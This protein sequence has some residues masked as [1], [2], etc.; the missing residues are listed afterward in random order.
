MSRDNRDRL[1]LAIG[2]LLIKGALLLALGPIHTPD[3]GGYAAYAQDILAGRLGD[4]GLYATTG[5]TTLFRVIGFPAVIAAFM[6]MGGPYWDWMLVIVQMLLSVAASLG[7]HVM[8]RRFGLNRGLAACAV[9]AAAVSLPLALDQAV[10]TDSPFSTLILACVLLLTLPLLAGRPV[11]VA[12]TLAAGLLF[13]AAF[14]LREATLFLSLGI[15]PLVALAGLGGT[16]PS[17]RGARHM[18]VVGIVFMTPLLLVQQG[19]REWNRARIGMPVITTGAQTTMFQALADAAVIDPVVLKGDD[20]VHRTARDMLQGDDFSRVLAMLDVLF[21]QHRMTAVDQMQAGFAAYF[22]AWRD[23]PGIMARMVL[24]HLRSNQAQLALRPVESVRELILWARHDDGGFARWRSVREGRW[25]MAPVVAMDGL[26]KAVSI[27]VF[28]AFVLLTPWR[29][30][31]DRLTPLHTAAAGLWLLYFALLGLYALVH[32]ETRYVAAV[33][34]LSVVVGI[35]NLDWAWQW[36]KLR[37]RT[38]ANGL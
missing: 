33:V 7:L 14:L 35:F 18:M 29:L 19:Y 5:P 17:W 3:S 12:A 22:Q 26:S 27:I 2:L 16:R 15:V 8:A 9:I 32:L 34:P 11:G 13:A 36:W 28:A 37:R 23:H 30:L 24:G 25:W 20:L 31:R 1:L 6:T 4:A 10:L 21:Q 38:A